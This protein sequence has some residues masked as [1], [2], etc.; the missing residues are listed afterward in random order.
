MSPAPPLKPAIACTS[1][2]HCSSFWAAHQCAPAL[3]IAFR[4]LVALLLMRDLFVRAKDL[5]VAAIDM[6]GVVQFLEIAFRH[7]GIPKPRNLHCQQGLIV[8]FRACWS[9]CP[10][11][12]TCSYAPKICSSL[13]LGRHSAGHDHG[14]R[15][16]CGARDFS[17]GRVQKTLRL[18][19]SEDGPHFSERGPYYDASCASDNDS[20]SCCWPLSCSLFLYA[21][22]PK[23]KRKG[24]QHT[25]LRQ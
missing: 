9:L 18:G 16:C 25:L 4:L 5:F 22:S 6:F 17:T 12:R 7:F 11:P 21:S 1:H 15:A 23:Q 2:F 14:L 24:R 10:R 19:A 8:R 3:F 20:R 13:P